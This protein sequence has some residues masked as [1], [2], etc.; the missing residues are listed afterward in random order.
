MKKIVI[1]L[2]AAFL[3][4]SCG[5]GTY[6]VSSGKADECYISFTSNTKKPVPLT[7]YIDGKE[8]Y[9]STVKE[10]AWRTDRKIK[11]TAKNTLTLAPGTHDV[12]VEAGGVEVYS[13]KL[14]IS[15]SE[16]KVVQL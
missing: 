3:F 9:V 1:A 12:K 4:T 13:K 8:Y 10:I 14:F 5:V 16:H 11:D 2:L 6:S 7:V 15:T